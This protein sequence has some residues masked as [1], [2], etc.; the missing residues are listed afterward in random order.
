VDPGDPIFRREAGRLLALLT[1]VFG[2]ENLPLAED[3]VQE[4]LAHAFEVWSYE[5]VPDH[6]AALLTVAAKN[7][8]L[9]VFRRERTA[10]AFAPELARFVESEWTLR[11]TL[12][13]LFVPDALRDDELRMMFSCCQPKL[14][15]EVQVA[16]VLKILCGFGVGEIASAFFAT[17]AAIE[18][19]LARGKKALAASKRLFEL[20]AADFHERLSTVQHVLYLLFN[21]GYHSASAEAVVR[22]D[23]CRE[24]MRLAQLLASYLPSAT[25]ATFA[26]SA[27]MCLHAARLPARIDEAGNLRALFDQ[28]RSRWDAELIAQGLALLE[29]AASGEAIS[30]YHV[31]AGIAA[32][33]ASAGSNA[34]TP[35]GE[36]VGH[37]DVLL[38]IDPSPVVALSRAIAIAEHRGAEQGLAALRAIPDAGRL[39]QYPFHAAALGELELRAGRSQNAREHFS[40]AL[41][42]ARNDGERRHLNARIEACKERPS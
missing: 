30:A 29:Q 42:L 2:V 5:G 12:D 7:R 4:T 27:L 8:A 10:R 37:Y 3:V 11:P 22:L 32:L 18:K 23:L 28:D 31:E 14:P 40:E 17:P 25:P 9:D 1:R 41:R 35:W 16:L 39:A 13:D 15:E 38:R 26:L 19:R 36:I 21:E 33:H 34:E 24:A 6:Y 20:S